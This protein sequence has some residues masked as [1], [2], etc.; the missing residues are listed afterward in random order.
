MDQKRKTMPLTRKSILGILVWAFGEA[1]NIVP[2]TTVYH[3]IQQLYLNMAF[4]NMKNG[5]AMTDEWPVDLNR[6]GE[7]WPVSSGTVAF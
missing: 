5:P 3:C 6:I 7:H 2:K 4:L 1:Q